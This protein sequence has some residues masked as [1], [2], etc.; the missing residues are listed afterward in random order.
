MSWQVVVQPQARDDI[1]GAAA[2][3]D[4]QSS[5]LGDQFIEEVLT[6]LRAL[7]VNPF[8]H[9]LRQRTKNIRWWFLRRFPYRIVYEANEKEHLVI[10]YAVVHSARHESVWQRR[11]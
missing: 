3:Y 6:A 4:D 5:G 2:W 7:K 9:T 8:I 10:V 11:N 1:T